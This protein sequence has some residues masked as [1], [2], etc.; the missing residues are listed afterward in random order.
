MKSDK[1]CVMALRL[2]IWPKAVTRE[3]PEINLE[4]WRG[5]VLPQRLNLVLLQLP[6]TLL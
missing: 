3:S 2:G 5:I 1:L 4:T 6:F